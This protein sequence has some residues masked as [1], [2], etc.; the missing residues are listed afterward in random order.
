SRLLAWLS[1]SGL[2]VVD[3]ETG[4]DVLR[5]N[6]EALALAFY[7]KTHKLAIGR[8]DGTVTILDA[9]TS[10]ELKRFRGHAAV[11]SAV[12]VSPDGSRLATGGADGTVKLWD[13]TSGM[14][15]LSFEEKGGPVFSVSFSADGEKLAAASNHAIYVWSAPPSQGPGRN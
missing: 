15:L 12:A 1:S 13:G 7:P 9:R 5:T 2:K 4:A 14:E 11:V 3:P 6:M 10:R 8:N